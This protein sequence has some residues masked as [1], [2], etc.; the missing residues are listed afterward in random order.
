M[1]ILV[2]FELSVGYSGRGFVYDIEKQEAV[3][4]Q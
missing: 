4:R 1:G 3:L 2:V